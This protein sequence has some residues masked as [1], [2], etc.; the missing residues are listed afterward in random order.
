LNAPRSSPAEQLATP[1]N[2][3][4]AQSVYEELI[5]WSVKLNS[6]IFTTEDKQQF[7]A[8]LKL[9]PAHEAAWQKLY[10]VEQNLGTIPAESRQV[11]VETLR[12]ADKQ[13]KR[14]AARRRTLKLLSLAFITIIGSALIANQYAPWQQTLHYTTSIGKRDNFLLADGTQLMLNTNSEVEIRLSLLKREIVI[15]RGEIYMETGKDSE[16]IIGRRSFWV[17]TEQ[18]KL[19]AVGTRFSVNQQLS[20]TKLHVVDGIVAMHVDNDLPPVRAYANE[21]Y[22]MID[23]V[24]AP[25]KM[26]TKDDGLRMDPMAWVN[27]MLV[28]KQMRLDEFVIELSRYQNLPVVCEP[29]VGSLKV[30]G[31]FQ[32]NRADPVEYAL[33]V[34]SRT[35]PVRMRKQDDIIFINKK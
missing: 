3:E 13:A 10:A 24:S 9:N 18:A 34:I 2:A 30:S 31:V 5:A 12:H 21:T 6:G 1:D 16:S 8:W 27:G 4:I 35:L 15:H 32:L 22:T 26:G 7:E 29:S 20:I 33:K 25:I 14:P 11:V 23:V 28:V 17:R 19:E